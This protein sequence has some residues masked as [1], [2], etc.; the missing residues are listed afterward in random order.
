MCNHRHDKRSIRCKSCHLEFMALLKVGKVSPIKGTYRKTSPCVCEYCGDIFR[1]TKGKAN[2]FCSFDCYVEY[3]RQTAS[4][5][6]RMRSSKRYLMWADVVKNRDGK[7]VHCGKTGKLIAH[8]KIA[9]RQNI[10][11]AF[12]LTNGE[13]VCYSCHNILHNNFLNLLSNKAAN[14]V[15]PRTGNPE[16]SMEKSRACVETIDGSREGKYSPAP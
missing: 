9:V 1:S 6:N 8:H 2:R 7:C 12:D 13:T 4:I 15:E 11:K 10:A 3:R 16:P 5:V 14:S